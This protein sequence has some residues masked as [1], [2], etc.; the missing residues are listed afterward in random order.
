MSQKSLFF[1]AIKKGNGIDMQ[2]CSMCSVFCF[3]FWKGDGW[4]NDVFRRLAISQNLG[5]D[6][7][8]AEFYIQL[9][10]PTQIERMYQY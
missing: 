4:E 2:K 3:V 1:H 7:A 9:F 8:R 5:V 6:P 10:P